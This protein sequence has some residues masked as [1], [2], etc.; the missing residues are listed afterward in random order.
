MAD[1]T[2]YYNGLP[3]VPVTDLDIVDYLGTTTLYAS[4]F[5]RGIWKTPVSLTCE[6]NLT[7]NEAA[8]S[9]QLHYQ[10][11]NQITST[12]DLVGG[13]GTKVQFKA[14]TEIVLSPGFLINAG[15]QL[16]AVIGACNS[17]SLPEAR[18]TKSGGD[19][20]QNVLNPLKRKVF[21][22]SQSKRKNK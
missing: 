13:N 16:N 22:T 4:T 6:T 11:S 12:T 8:I 10:A 15:S 18:T 20:I 14:G 17:G 2:P 19:A 9:G 1:W 5:G 21:T 7:V 3:R